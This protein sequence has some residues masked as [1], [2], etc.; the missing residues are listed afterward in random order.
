MAS[1]HDTIIFPI[2]S[3]HIRHNY[4]LTPEKLQKQAATLGYDAGRADASLDYWAKRPVCVAAGLQRGHLLALRLCSSAAF[5]GINMPL[6][7]GCA[8]ERPHPYPATC[9]LL[10]DALGRLREAQAEQRHAAAAKA[11]K[12]AEEA[13]KAK[14]DGDEELTEK[15]AGVAKEV[16]DRA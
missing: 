1:A 4:F 15:A 14:E 12:L 8:P 16:G 11:A 5:P 3:A 2:V 9:A 6:N 13:R 7:D 10:N